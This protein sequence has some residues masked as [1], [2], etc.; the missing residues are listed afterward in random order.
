MIQSCC[1][2]SHHLKSFRGYSRLQLLSDEQ[3]YSWMFLRD[4][5]LDEPD[6]GNLPMITIYDLRV[7]QS[8]DI[9]LALLNHVRCISPAIVWHEKSIPNF[10]LPKY[11]RDSCCDGIQC[12]DLRN[13]SIV[14][15]CSSL[16]SPVSLIMCMDVV[17]KWQAE[18]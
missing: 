18:H 12:N 15:C 1:L 8:I 16:V 6:L 7:D 3:I 2:S 17:R 14:L 13:R 5:Y 4:F 11:L 10:M 9:G